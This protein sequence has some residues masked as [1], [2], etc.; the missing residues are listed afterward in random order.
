MAVTAR[1]GQRFCHI[2]ALPAPL[3]LLPLLLQALMQLCPGTEQTV[4]A[5]P[6]RTSRAPAEKKDA[7]AVKSLKLYGRVDELSSTMHG[8]G[9]KIESLTLPSRV[10]KVRMG[11]PAYYAGMA[12][13]DLIEKMTLN[14]G[15]LQVVFRR[16]GKI[17]G[18]NIATAPPAQTNNTNTNTPLRPPAARS[19]RTLKTQIADWSYLKD[20][21]ICVL[22]DR[23][24]SMEDEIEG[25]RQTKWQWMQTI[26]RDFAFEAK[27]FAGKSLTVLTFNR[28]FKVTEN[29]TPASLYQVFNGL[30]PEGGTDLYSPLAY[31]LERQ[32][33]SNPPKPLLVA[34]ITDGEPDAYEQVAALIRAA[35]ARQKRQT[36]LQ[37]TFLGIGENTIGEGVLNY[38]D[39]ALVSQGARFDVVDSVSFED[40]KQLG[41][42]AALM[43]AFRRPRANQAR[44]SDNE[45]ARL[46]KKLQ[47]QAAREGS[48]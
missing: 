16:N 23:S 28:Q 25:G 9:L 6:V 41:I 5:E 24:G 21:D 37:I 36:D 27:Q 15:T 43:E 46:L 17:Y 12:E 1:P 20:Y 34:V 19:T 33:G 45:L 32:A 35:T 2:W 30:T 39:D 31:C 13:E 3:P 42:A 8:A 7:S 11:S 4:L 48:H 47:N 18:A 40:L 10:V 14:A 38:F 22:I 44:Y 26:V 29:V